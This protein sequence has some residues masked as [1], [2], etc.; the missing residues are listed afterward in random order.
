MRTARWIVA[1]A[2]VLTVIFGDLP[3]QAHYVAVIQNSCHAPAFAVL[4]LITL[5]LLPPQSRSAPARAGTTV[6]IMLLL[7]IATEGIQGLVGRDA[8]LEDVIN[9]VA[10]SLIATTLWLSRRWR[11]NAHG[12][13]RIARMA[14]LFVCACAGAYWLNPILQCARS[15]W[16]RQEQFPIL[17]QFHSSSDLTFI[18]S[19][20]S[21]THLVDTR[22][23]TPPQA[24][25]A[26]LDSGP[27]PGITLSE[28]MPDWR[29]YH[30]LA[31]D[32]GNPS[33]GALLLRFRVNDRAHQGVTD[34]RFNTD[35]FLPKGARTTFRIPLDDIEHSP[36]T[37][38][39]DMSRIAQLILFRPGGGAPDQVV[40]LYRIWLE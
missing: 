4:S 31:L 2:I 1:A 32:V 17:V 29:G 39:M 18:S 11:G 10:G 37:R 15:Y 34:D 35:F 3:G 27:Y 36:R 23:G 5:E 26:R 7:G 8:E 28:P 25:Q 12:T 19:S 13:T 30:T 9:D 20:A 40:R 33:P 22:T 14:A 21:D 16:N 38:R 24:L 6:A